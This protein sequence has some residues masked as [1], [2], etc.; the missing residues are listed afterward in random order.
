MEYTIEV[1]K[2]SNQ[3]ENLSNTLG[4]VT[5]KSKEQHEKMSKAVQV[6]EEALAS[7]LDEINAVY[8]HVLA[9]YFSPSTSS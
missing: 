6:A 2:L 3:V 5:K 1:S 4:E 9:M 7:H 8:D